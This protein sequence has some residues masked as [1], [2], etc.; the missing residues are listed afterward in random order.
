MSTPQ[1]IEAD[2]ARQRD[3]LAST[4][5]QLQTQLQ[6]RARSTAKT[7]AVAAGVVLLGL[8]GLTVWRRARH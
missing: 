1:E 8:V 4:I 6:D 5:D 2:I 3:E 7:V